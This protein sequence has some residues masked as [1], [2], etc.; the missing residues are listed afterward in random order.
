MVAT[1]ILVTVL[2]ALLTGATSYAIFWNLL[3]EQAAEKG[4]ASARYNAEKIEAWAREKKTSIERTAAHLSSLDSYDPAMV[5]KMLVTAAEAD[6]SF[7]SA[8]I[9]FDDGRLLDAKGWVPSGKYDAR[10][11]PWYTLA[12]KAQTTIFTPVYLDQNKISLVTSIALPVHIGGK[13]VVLAANIPLDQVLLKLGSIKHGETGFGMLIDENGTIIAHRDKGKVLEPMEG[14]APGLDRQTAQAVMAN[15]QGITILGPSMHKQMLVYVSVPSCGWK[16]LL[17]APEREFMAP[18]RDMAKTLALVLLAMLAVMASAGA[19]LGG[20]L[21]RPI[22]TIIQH[23]RKLADGNLAEEI[24]VDGVSEISDLG[25]AL[26]RMRKN[27][28]EVMTSIEKEVRLLK[29]QAR[30]LTSS[31]DDVSSG[32]TDFVSQLSHDIKTPLTLI[33]GYTRGIQVGVTDSPEKIDEYLSGIF[34]RSEHIERITEDILDSIYAVKRTVILDSGPIAIREFAGLLVENARLQVEASGRRFHASPIPEGGGIH[35]DLSKLLR[36]WGN[37]V[38]NGI[39]YSD[40]GSLVSVLIC[41]TDAWLSCS[42]KDEGIGMPEE[43]L[44]KIFDMFYR[45]KQ[46]TVKGYGI[47]LAISKAILEAHGGHI[48]VESELGKGSCFTFSIP[49]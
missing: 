9:G 29:T 30:K 3:Y 44:D 18:V 16:L 20:A 2:T 36:V 10:S 27:H 22:E 12:E 49:N 31:I 48:T 13:S 26:N 19:V 21:S 4:L 42:V 34:T 46:K 17:F 14:A 11:R 35:G 33:K 37:L 24:V 6:S 45:T 15:S 32:I 23:V 47:G 25:R 28:A 5:I 41:V 40:P 8:F 39:K 1:L 7:Y 43:E 38:S